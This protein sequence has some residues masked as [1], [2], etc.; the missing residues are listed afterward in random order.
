MTLK[1]GC[2]VESCDVAN[3]SGRVGCGPANGPPCFKPTSSAS[4]NT[5][6]VSPKANWPSRS[7]SPPR[8]SGGR[9]WHF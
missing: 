9:Y 8:A 5:S 6:R 2:C 3:S 1:M 4:R 7:S